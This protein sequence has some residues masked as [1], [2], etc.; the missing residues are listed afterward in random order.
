VRQRGRGKNASSF[1]F[2]FF[3]FSRSDVPLEEQIFL[4][5]STQ[6]RSTHRKNC[7]RFFRGKKQGGEK[8]DEAKNNNNQHRESTLSA[9]PNNKN[10]EKPKKKIKTNNEKKWGRERANTHTHTLSVVSRFLLVF[11]FCQ[12]SIALHCSEKRRKKHAG[13]P[14]FFSPF[15]ERDVKSHFSLCTVRG[16]AFQFFI[17]HESPE[18]LSPDIS[19]HHQKI[20]RFLFTTILCVCVFPHLFF[21]FVVSLGVILNRDLPLGPRHPAGRRRQRRSFGPREPFQQ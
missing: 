19:I 18:S 13:S 8:N 4:R 20:V 7:L 12:K 11:F 16:F 17:R 2:S 15:A 1:F 9:T 21:L 6:P 10:N 5:V 3:F 14:F